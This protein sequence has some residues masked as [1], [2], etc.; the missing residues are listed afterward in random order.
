MVRVLGDEAEREAC[1]VGGGHGSSADCID[2]LVAG[3]DPGASDVTTWGEE[4]DAFFF[5][6]VLDKKTYI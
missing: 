4:V 3:L 6:P 5:I 2:A 1:D